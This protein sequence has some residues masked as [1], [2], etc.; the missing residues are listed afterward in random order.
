LAVEV[1]FVAHDRRSGH[2]A[3]DEAS[4]DV[5]P[6]V[7]IGELNFASLSI[8][9]LSPQDLK[10]LVVGIVVHAGADHL[11]LVAD[12]ASY[13]PEKRGDAVGDRS[14]KIAFG[15]QTLEDALEVGVPV[16]GVFDVE[17][18]CVG[19]QAV[20]LRV[21]ARRARPV[22]IRSKSWWGSGASF[23]QRLSSAAGQVGE[24]IIQHI[25]SLVDSEVDV[26]LEIS[27]RVPDGIPDRVVRTVSENAATL[28]FEQFEFEFE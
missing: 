17:D 21:A 5:S 13:A 16:G 20:R 2:F 10:S 19:E 8:N 4:G 7:P 23:P 24:E 27:A 26:V 28:K 1:G 25:A 9:D 18:R 6:I 14:L 3:G 15:R 12:D 11:G 22:A